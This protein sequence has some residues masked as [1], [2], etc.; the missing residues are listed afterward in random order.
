[1]AV[2][3]CAGSSQAAGKALCH[4]GALRARELIKDFT[5]QPVIPF[6]PAEEGN[7]AARGIGNQMELAVPAAAEPV[8]ALQAGV[9]RT[10]GSESGWPG[11]TPT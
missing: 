5:H 6:T 2:Q 9:R 8:L 4:G 11:L 7:G 1:M 3:A 10:L